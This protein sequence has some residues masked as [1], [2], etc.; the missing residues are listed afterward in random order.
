M[1]CRL[2]RPPSNA[3]GS[4]A[5]FRDFGALLVVPS[6]LHAAL[7]ESIPICNAAS[8]CRARLA[9]ERRPQSIRPSCP[10]SQRNTVRPA[11]H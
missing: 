6:G 11:R 5:V 9:V 7:L 8:L 2:Q 4:G 10:E 3:A 1:P